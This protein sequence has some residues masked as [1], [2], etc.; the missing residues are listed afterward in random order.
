MQGEKSFIKSKIA[1]LS[2][3]RRGLE[4]YTVF[5]LKKYNDKIIKKIPSGHA[6]HQGQ[7]RTTFLGRYKVR[8]EP[9]LTKRCEKMR[10]E[11]K[12]CEKSQVF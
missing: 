3:T 8:K 5:T 9:S 2:E 4:N 11:R 12:R 6:N 1:K 7:L 10:K